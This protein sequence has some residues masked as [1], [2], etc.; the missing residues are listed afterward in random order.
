MEA[1][2][3]TQKATFHLGDILSVI[4]GLVVSP[5]QMDGVVNMLRFMTEMPICFS[6]EM[7]PALAVC[8]TLLR[9]QFPELATPE[10]AA[11][12]ERLRVQLKDERKNEKRRDLVLSWLDEQVSL[13]GAWH[14]VQSL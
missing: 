5:R 8:K 9:D 4:H 1:E 2:V 7:G 10:V 11:A 12:V 6:Y 14:K 3:E 13:R